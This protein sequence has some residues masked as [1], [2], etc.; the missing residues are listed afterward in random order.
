MLFFRDAGV[1]CLLVRQPGRILMYFIYTAVLRE[2]LPCP[3]EKITIFRSAL[4]ALFL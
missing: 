1:S 2:Q 4:L 3:R